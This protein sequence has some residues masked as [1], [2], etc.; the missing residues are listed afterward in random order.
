MALIV[1]QTMNFAGYQRDVILS[2]LYYYLRGMLNRIHYTI[3]TQNK[4][5]RDLADTYWLDAINITH[6][7]HR[8]LPRYAQYAWSDPEGVIDFAPDPHGPYQDSWNPGG[9]W[10]GRY[11]SYTRVRGYPIIKP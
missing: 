4:G 6:L 7:A 3:T 2:D 1:E 11:D 9:N 8:E 5:L 10:R